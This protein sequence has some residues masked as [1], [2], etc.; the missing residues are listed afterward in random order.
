[1]LVGRVLVGGVLVEGVLVEGVLAWGVLCADVLGVNM[2]T[3]VT[4]VDDWDICM[5]VTTAELRQLVCTE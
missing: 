3:V 2:L 5:L 4:P 1:M